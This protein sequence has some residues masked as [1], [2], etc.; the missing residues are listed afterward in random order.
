MLLDLQRQDG[1]GGERGFMGGYILMGARKVRVRLCAVLGFFFD[2][3]TNWIQS[4]PSFLC[5]TVDVRN[6]E[7]E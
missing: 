5:T 4:W 7:K 2:L 3:P 1:N 6:C